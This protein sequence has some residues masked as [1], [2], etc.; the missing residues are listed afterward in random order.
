MIVKKQPEF[1]SKSSCCKDDFYNKHVTTNLSL[2][3]LIK[4]ETDEVF[5]YM[6]ESTEMR[7]A[8]NPRKAFRRR[9]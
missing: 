8:K 6:N 2:H 1:V 9:N 4:L 3:K 7:E 5:E